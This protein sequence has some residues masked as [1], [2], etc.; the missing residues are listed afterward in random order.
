MRGAH[1][2]DIVG[3]FGIEL[4]ADA[5]LALTCTVSRKIWWGGADSTTWWPVAEPW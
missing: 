1:I 5:E 3:W 4:T 2:R